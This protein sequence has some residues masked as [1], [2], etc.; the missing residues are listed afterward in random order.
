M[1]TSIFK[2]LIAILAITF[3][4]C[5]TTPEPI[6]Y[7]ED[8]CHFCEM[9]IVSQVHSAQ[10]VST[11]GKQFKYDAIECMMND[12]IK[13]QTEMA[14]KRVANFSS[15]GEMI[16]V[17]KAGFIVNDSINSP[18]GENLAAIEIGSNENLYT[19]SELKARFL[20]EDSVTL[21]SN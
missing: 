15:P 12:I 2:S 7:G 8:S 3:I 20:G 13:N 6:K 5:S 4:S 16:D 19:W 11:K 14:V 17:E 1:K 10:A 21:N 18:M 9:T